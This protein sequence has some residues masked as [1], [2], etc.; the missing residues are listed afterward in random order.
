MAVLSY[1]V[2][3]GG[4]FSFDSAL[5]ISRSS[6]FG[7]FILTMDEGFLLAAAILSAIFMIGVLWQPRRL[8]HI[9][10]AE[11]IIFFCLGGFLVFK[12]ALSPKQIYN[13][14]IVQV[15]Q[16]IGKSEQRL[17][18]FQSSEKEITA[19]A[20]STNNQVHKWEYALQV[21]G[22]SNYQMSVDQQNSL[23]ATE[24]LRFDFG[25]STVSL[26]QVNEFNFER[27]DCTKFTIDSNYYTIPEIQ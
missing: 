15:I 3:F 5:D 22:Y 9:F 12:I 13:N 19:N 25:S 14:Q 27:C 8:F 6:P 1:F 20:S 11:I 10:I 7:Y 17:A 26:H 2:L 21:L 18:E 4:I 16:A 24:M 23:A